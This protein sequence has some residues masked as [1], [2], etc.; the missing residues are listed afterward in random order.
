MA[1]YR[2]D[3]TAHVTMAARQAQARHSAA[4]LEKAGRK[5]A[6][7]HLEGQAIARTFWG[8]A[9]CKHLETYSDYANRLPR[10]RTYVRG[11]AV[12]DL[13][14]RREVCGPWFVARPS[15]P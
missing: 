14:S 8:K 3:F 6:P 1:W 15:T 9:W 10:G 13:R 12:L 11:R 7:V 2:Q 5:L 4:E